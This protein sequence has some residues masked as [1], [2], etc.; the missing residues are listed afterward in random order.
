MKKE[1]PKAYVKR[2]AGLLLFEKEECK[3]MYLNNPTR[4]YKIGDRVK[5]GNWD[6]CHILEL[7]DNGKYYK[8]LAITPDIQY[9]IDK[10][11]KFKISYLPWVSILPYRTPFEAKKPKKLIQNEDLFHNFSQR[12]IS[13]IIH[14]YYRFGIELNPKYQRGNVWSLTDKVFLI[15]SIFKNVDIGKFTIIKRLYSDNKKRYEILDGKQ[16]VIALI[17]FFEDKFTYKGL[18]FSELNWRDQSYFKNYY[19]S[20]AESKPMSKKQKYRYFLNLNVAG[21]PVDSKHIDYVKQLLK[22]TK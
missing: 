6:W 5:Y 2:Q 9:G 21:K 14:I 1:T 8:V 12:D 7:F 13:S 3:Q 10:G 20:Y 11:F 4:I 15:D 16:R 17:E 19:I 22:G 18:K